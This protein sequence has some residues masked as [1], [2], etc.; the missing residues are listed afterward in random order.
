MLDGSAVKTPQNTSNHAWDCVPHLL[1]GRHRLL[2][3]S[4]VNTRQNTRRTAC[5]TSLASGIDCRKC[6]GGSAWRTHTSRGSLAHL[7]RSASKRTVRLWLRCSACCSGVT[8]PGPGKGHKKWDY[9]IR[10]QFDLVRSEVTDPDPGKGHKK[11]VGIQFV[12]LW[13]EVT[14]Q[15]PGKGHRKRQ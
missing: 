15:G 2:D 12:L 7:V 14:A 11:S 9:T 6:G 13:S 4:A 8:A 3:G 5:P 10:I 1:G